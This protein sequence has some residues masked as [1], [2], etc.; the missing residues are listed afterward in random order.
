MSSYDNGGPEAVSSLV[1][2]RTFHSVENSC[3]KFL[4]RSRTLHTG[5]EGSW[6][7]QGHYTKGVR[8][9]VRYTNESVGH[10]ICQGEH[11]TGIRE[12]GGGVDLTIVNRPL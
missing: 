3:G 2:S 12:I 5:V 7:E 4:V 11:S 1:R 8:F 10:L 9:L 6:S